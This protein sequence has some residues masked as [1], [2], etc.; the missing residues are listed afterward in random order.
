MRIKLLVS[1]AGNGFAYG[2]GE[3][4]DFPAPEAGRFIT[5]GYAEAVDE[6]RAEKK[7]PVKR[8]RARKATDGS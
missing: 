6:E 8:T 5:A 7:A 1:I 2:A 4:A 3:V